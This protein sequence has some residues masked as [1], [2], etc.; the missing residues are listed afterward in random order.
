M[1]RGQGELTT[2]SQP[3][4]QSLNN[5]VTNAHQLSVDPSALFNQATMVERHQQSWQYLLRGQAPEIP[6]SSFGHG[7]HS[8]GQKIADSFDALH[9]IREH[10]ASS[11]AEAA[12]L[13]RQFARS[14]DHEDISS[15]QQIARAMQ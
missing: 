13:A 2:H 5:V 4:L 12:R 1:K 3:N 7:L 15:A 10:Q 11:L 9:A 8:Q 6:I 14:V